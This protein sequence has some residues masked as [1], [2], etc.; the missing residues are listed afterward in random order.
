MKRLAVCLLLFVSAA[1]NAQILQPVQNTI[2]CGT[3]PLLE[4]GI[5]VPVRAVY[6]PDRHRYLQHTMAQLLRGEA[7]Q[8]VMLGDSIVGD[9]FGPQYAASGWHRGTTWGM[10]PL[11]EL[12]RTT[13]YAVVSVLG[14]TGAW[15]YRLPGN[16]QAYVLD[17]L[18]D[19]VLIGG[20]SNR[21]DI[22]AI[23][24]V[25][26][27]IRTARPQTEFILMT[28]AVNLQ[29]LPAG[30]SLQL[31]ESDGTYEA[32]LARLADELETGF[33]N[34]R[35][36]YD[37]F[38]VEANR[39]RPDIN[40]AWFQR[41]PIHANDY[42]RLVLREIITMFF[43][44]A[45]ECQD[46]AAAR[47]RVSS[48]QAMTL[49]PATAAPGA[50][51][52]VATVS[53]P[54][55]QSIVTAD[56][57]IASVEMDIDRSGVAD[58]I[59]L[60]AGGTGDTDRLRIALDPMSSTQPPIILPLNLAG[61]LKVLLADLDKNELPDLVVGTDAATPQ[62]YV[63]LNTGIAGRPFFDPVLL[64]KGNLVGCTADLTAVD[65]NADGNTDLLAANA[66]TTTLG[67]I[68]YYQIDSTDLQLARQLPESWQV[69]MQ[70]E[71]IRVGGSSMQHLAPTLQIAGTRGEQVVAQ[72]LGV[73]QP[74]APT[75]TESGSGGGGSMLW[76][77]LIM[78]VLGINVLRR[79]TPK[80]RVLSRDQRTI[81][82][83]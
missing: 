71:S 53:G 30:S 43:R 61:G 46:R 74:V 68:D 41:D 18:P 27:Q 3:R 65:M 81:L 25:V 9:T 57:I 37:E 6:K 5:D 15:Y 44:P 51:M 22:D 67:S 38:V 70:I 10:E 82:N 42:G 23:R 75:P 29:S 16:V 40:Q 49:T 76:P 11:A 14:S 56:T 83:A 26:L 59:E 45:V 7:F 4:Q 1:I 13:V 55:G 19:L 34:M 73:A 77:E 66:C 17:H 39:L 58:R 50:N 72:E 47:R 64:M 80:R 36:A 78:G 60:R 20:I 62:L 2:F 28:G 54:G 21:D 48:P 35:G 24:D 63:Y 12:Y 8:T 31:N 79:R 32:R 69:D 52:P 33:I